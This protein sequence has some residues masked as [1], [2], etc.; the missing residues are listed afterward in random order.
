[1]KNVGQTKTNEEILKQLYVTANDLMT[2][3]PE[4]KYQRALGYINEV[5][6]EMKEKNYFL[7]TTQKKLALTKLVK[8]KFGF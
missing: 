3:I 2:L 5:R 1:M 7:P 6:E 8:K 4:L